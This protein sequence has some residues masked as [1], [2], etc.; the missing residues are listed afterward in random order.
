MSKL[1]SNFFV[2]VFE[3]TI[4]KADPDLAT[5]VGLMIKWFNFLESDKVRD[6]TAWSMVTKSRNLTSADFTIEMDITSEELYDRITTHPDV[7]ERWLTRIDPDD[8]DELDE[9]QSFRLAMG[10]I[11]GHY[12]GRSE[13]NRNLGPNGEMASADVFAVFYKNGTFNFNRPD[14]AWYNQLPQGFSC[15]KGAEPIRECNRGFERYEPVPC[16]EI[17]LK[18]AID[19]CLRGDIETRNQPDCITYVNWT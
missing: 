12:E 15:G 7:M 11:S 18:I 10:I 5:P 16:H 6:G 17:V 19:R 9:L 1:F 14:C 4:E 2:L 8:P 3:G 13:E